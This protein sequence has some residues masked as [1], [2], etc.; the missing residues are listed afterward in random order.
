M[1]HSAQDPNKSTGIG[2]SGSPD[3]A[4]VGNVVGTQDTA[5]K[6]PAPGHDF[7]VLDASSRR[8]LNEAKKTLSTMPSLDETAIRDA[9]QIAS[10]VTQAAQFMDAYDAVLQQTQRQIAEIARIQQQAYNQIARDSYQWSE[11]ARSASTALNMFAGNQ[12]SALNA[13]LHTHADYVFNTIY[14]TSSALISVGEAARKAFDSSWAAF[15]SS[16][17]GLWPSFK[18]LRKALRQ[19]L[20]DAF[21]SARLWPAPSMPDELVARIA[22][23]AEAGNLRAVVLTVWNHYSRR[24]HEHLADAVATWWDDSEFAARQSIIEQALTAHRQKMYALTIPALLAQCEGIAGDFVRSYVAPPG[25]KTAPSLGKSGQIVRHAIEAAGSAGIIDPDDADILHMVLIEAVL[26]HVQ[27]VAFETA[28]F[29]A[30]Y[31]RIR[32]RRDLNRHGTL[33]GIQINY[34]TAMNSLRCFLLLDALYA[35]RKHARTAS[36]I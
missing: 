34:A 9:A 3:G 13:A 30:E 31:A 2:D 25:G 4:T 7:P 12:V 29:S 27:T 6:P 36:T 8:H 16:L 21:L 23:H 11:M 14:S 28:N 26:A 10:Q 18:R 33:H 1:T 15:D 24:N 19:R 32:K 20:C 22:D 17:A 5:H 35:L